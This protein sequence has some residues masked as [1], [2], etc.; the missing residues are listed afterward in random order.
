MSFDGLLMHRLISEI[1]EVIVGGRIDKIHQPEKDELTIQIRNNSNQFTLFVSVDASI[2]YFTLASEKKENPSSPPMFCMLMRKHLTNGKIVDFYQQGLERVAVLEIES[3]NELGDLE[4]K[5]LIIEIMGKHSNAIL[6]KENLIVIDSIKRITPDMS[7]IRSILPGLTYHQMESTKVTLDADWIPV[8]KKQGDAIPVY[9]AL[10][11]T[12]EGFS[13]LSSK[14]VLNKAHIYNDLPVIELT[15]NDIERLD[16]QIQALRTEIYSNCFD[17]YVFYDANNRMRNFYFLDSAYSDYTP[18]YYSSLS[19]AI[20]KF[21]ANS[22]KSLKIHQRTHDLKKTLSQKIERAKSKLGKLELELSTAENSEDLKI[23]G[24]LILANIYALSKGTNQ[25]KVLN[26]YV[27]PPEEMTIEMDVRL[28]PSENAQSYFKKYT[29]SKTA[30]N[31]LAKQISSTQH[32]IQYLEHILV[33]LELSEDSKTIEEIRQELADEGIIKR[34]NATKT[35]KS[36]NKSS[37]HTFTSSDG[38]TIYAGKN[39]VQNDALT[40]KLASNKDL[41]LHTKIIPGSH[42]IIRTEGKEVPE[43]TL[44][45]AAAIAAYYSSA[46]DSENVPVDYTLVKYVVKPNGSKPGMVIY[47]HNKTLFV[48]PDISLIDQLKNKE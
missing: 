23:K 9:K 43:N 4:V 2:P 18:E 6:V 22:N 25:A 27:D 19:K 12:L 41:W 45:E 36:N 46:R 40:I 17:G 35:K 26:Y 3:R 16:V 38:F 15:D 39:N 13:P 20:D 48:T 44:V 30:V 42:V 31:E 5:K 14:L 8:L 24:E 29:K 11:M 7:R 28:D 1:K 33:Q 37:Y 32:E 34:R 21:Y 47:T 10:Y